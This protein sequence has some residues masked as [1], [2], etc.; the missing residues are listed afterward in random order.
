MNKFILILII[1]LFAFLNH[2]NTCTKAHPQPLVVT[3]FEFIYEKNTVLMNYKLRIDPVI[4][5]N[6]Y[7]DIDL[8]SDEKTSEEELIN[9]WDRVISKNL[10]ARMNNR[11]LNFEYIS[12]ILINKRDFRSLNDYLE[13]NFKAKNPIILQTN[14][15]YVKYSKKYLP[16]DPYGD[17]FYYYDNIEND[18]LIE[19]INIEETNLSGPG[20]YSTDYRFIEGFQ[21][22]NNITKKPEKSWIDNIREISTSLTNKV[23]SFDFNNPMFFIS[24]F[25]ILFTAGAL[26]ALTPGHGKS[27]LAA[28]LIGK[29][30]SK[31]ID[32]LILGIS[33][34]L[35]HT[36]IIYIIGFILLT[37]NRT[38]ETTSIVIFMEKIS[39][40]LFLGLGTIL[41]Y[42]GYK[43]YK[44]YKIYQEQYGRLYINIRDKKYSYNQDNKKSNIKSKWGLFYAGISGGIVPCI[45]ALS[46]LFLFASLGKVDLGLILVFI[47]SLGLATTTI[48]IGLFLLYGKD[49]FKLEEKIGPKVEFILPMISGSVI[50]LFGIFYI[51]TK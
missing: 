15:V 6:V 2:L 21:N 8:N 12:S 18:N 10:I 3:E 22:T 49:K 46:I 16:D 35:A 17:V 40:W 4:I 25:V 9:Y 13:I 5:D 47:F 23:K 29:Q 44:R 1:L 37:L 41:C 39:A 32:V 26:H 20:E 24:A 28:F 33:I 36:A 30:G 45:D 38:S 19:R 51:F 50:S 31:L 7:P 14:S 42:S 34:T 48:L 27:M 43:K 11:D